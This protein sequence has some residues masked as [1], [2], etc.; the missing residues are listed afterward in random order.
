MPF[1][2][3]D[4]QCPVVVDGEQ[5]GVASR[6]FVGQPVEQLVDQKTPFAAALTD[7]IKVGDTVRTASNGGVQFEVDVRIPAQTAADTIEITVPT[8]DNS[9]DH[10]TM[11]LTFEDVKIEPWEISVGDTTVSGTIG[12]GSHAVGYKNE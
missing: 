9:F 12:V 10:D 4:K 7:K 8:D 3:T 2:C 6:V 1:Q 11:V 5:V